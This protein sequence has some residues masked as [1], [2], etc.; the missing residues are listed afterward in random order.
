MNIHYFGIRHHGVGSSKRLILALDKLK[1]KKVLIEGASDCTHLL[2]LLAHAQ[3]Q[4]P[5][6]LLAYATDLPE[7]HFYYPFAEFSPE[8]QA[9]LWAIQH[10]AEV[11]FI[12]LPVAVSLALQIQQYK[13]KQAQ[14][15]DSDSDTPSDEL[16]K[17]D[18]VARFDDTPNKSSQN[19]DPIGQVGQMLGFADGESFW[20]DVIEQSGDDEK[21]FYVIHE[22]MTALRQSAFDEQ[23][24]QDPTETLREAYMRQEIRRHTK[25]VGEL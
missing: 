6:A 11:A 3:M 9:C 25:N 19:L 21:I 10:G 12:D 13:D 18:D 20:N 8:Y 17:T 22:M 7:C 2:P 16:I 15:A 1:P 4:P 24:D 23:N 5:V 14:T